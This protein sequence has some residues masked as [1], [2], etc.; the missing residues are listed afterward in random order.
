M[1]KP[2]DGA[3]TQ[4]LFRRLLP[5]IMPGSPEIFRLPEVDTV[6]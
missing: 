3:P 1:I 5:K 4:K 2:S 6:V